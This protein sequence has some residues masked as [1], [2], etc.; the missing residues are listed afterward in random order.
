MRWHT[1]FAGGPR[2][3]LR[4]GEAAF[5]LALVCLPV[6]AGRT[7][8]KTVASATAVTRSDAHAPRSDRGALLLSG[9]GLLALGTLLRRLRA[10]ELGT[11]AASQTVHVPLV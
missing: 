9:M 1:P 8:P 5:V 6:S 7:L 2:R 11:A 4:V 10:A 3:L